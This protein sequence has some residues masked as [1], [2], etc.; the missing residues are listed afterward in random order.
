MATSFSILVGIIETFLFFYLFIY[1]I[2]SE[3]LC[4]LSYRL[5]EPSPFE[6]LISFNE[7]NFSKTLLF[8]FGL[9]GILLYS[10]WKSFFKCIQNQ[11]KYFLK[12]EHLSF[13]GLLILGYSFFFYSF[14]IVVNLV[15]V[16]Y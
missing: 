11:P 15:L 16:I 4:D 14:P 7:I 2:Y 3:K 6:S 8:L 9:E 10:R 12:K 13:M 1:L 5:M